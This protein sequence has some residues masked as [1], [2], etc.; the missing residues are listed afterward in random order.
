M[1]SRPHSITCT[2]QLVNDLV[3]TRTSKH[4]WLKYKRSTRHLVW[5]E[6]TFVHMFV[7]IKLYIPRFNVMISLCPN[8]SNIIF[9]LVSIYY[10]TNHMGLWLVA[11]LVL[12]FMTCLWHTVTLKSVFY[13]NVRT[14]NNPHLTY[15]TH[16]RLA[17]EQRNKTT[18]NILYILQTKNSY[19]EKWI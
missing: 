17:R 11:I 4:V 7:F 19:I 6:V 5:Y 13:M 14:G 15:W 16:F 8:K 1:Y 12:L 3:C 18:W 9:D 2:G 10:M